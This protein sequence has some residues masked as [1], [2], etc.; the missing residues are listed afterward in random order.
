MIAR[1]WRDSRPPLPTPW[2]YTETDVMPYPIYGHGNSILKLIISRN[3]IQTD[4]LCL[5]VVTLLNSNLRIRT[6]KS[7]FLVIGL[8]AYSNPGAE[9]IREYTKYVIFSK[10]RIPNSK[11]RAKGNKNVPFERQF[12]QIKKKYKNLNLGILCFKIFAIKFS[13]FLLGQGYTF[14]V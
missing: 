14:N 2:A 8:S 5:L 1:A 3:K 4:S 12:C 10:M 7:F 9:C 13:N 11:N 6:R